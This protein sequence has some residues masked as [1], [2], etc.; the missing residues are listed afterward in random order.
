MAKKAATR[1]V[2][3]TSRASK[4]KTGAAKT[5]RVGTRRPHVRT[6]NAPKGW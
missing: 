4:T 2:T 1:T 3:K 6:T 5:I